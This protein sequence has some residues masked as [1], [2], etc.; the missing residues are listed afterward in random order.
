[1][2]PDWWYAFEIDTPE[3][4]IRETV[5]RR[6]GCEPEDVE[7]LRYGGCI[8]ARKGQAKEAEG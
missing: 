1:M 8:C 3:E 2:S 6:D 5:A 7:L 4:V